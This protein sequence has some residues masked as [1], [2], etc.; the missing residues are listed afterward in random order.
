MPGF[1]PEEL[2]SWSGGAWRHGC[3]RAVGGIS[4]DT[5]QLRPGDLY[6]ALSGT[7]FDGHDFVAKAAAAGAC[8]AVVSR[9][10][11][12]GLGDRLPLLEVQDPLIALQEMAASYRRKRGVPIVGVT[13]STG[14]TTVKEMIAGMLAMAMPTARSRGNWNNE[15]GLPL[16]L[17]AMGEEARAGVFELGISH[18][19]EMAPLCRIA[20]PTWGVLTLIGP[21][22]LEFFGS[23]E[24]IAREKGAMLRCLPPEGA[25]VL[26]AD[27]PWFGL[28]AGMTRVRVITVSRKS[29]A[30]YRLAASDG[31]GSFAIEERASG[32]TQALRVPLPGEHIVHDALLAAAVARG[33]G[34]A[35]PHIAEA[36]A[37]Y[38]PLPMRWETRTAGGLTVIND[39][40]NSNP[41]S[42]AA[43]LRAFHATPAT[44]RKW[45]VLG[46]MLEI[47]D[48]AAAEHRRIGSVV[49]EGD[50]AGLVCVGDLGAAIA[51][52]AG[53]AGMPADRLRRCRTPAEAG[54]FLNVRVRPGDMVL[55]KAS[56]GIHLEEA[57]PPLLEGLPNGGAGDTIAI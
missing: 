49:A 7:N 16:S 29:G 39:A 30:D 47:G 46:D 42:L 41:L 53:D 48:G 40:Y 36:L 10:R 14:K 19:G 27:D 44:G 32:A 21:V 54:A 22:H 18:P 45:L 43:A 6:V 20:Q 13:G 35:W 9:A 5:R 8:G 50:W 23:E 52:G 31:A 55:L 12:G 57:L 11:A 38:R 2:A 15:V 51:D 37:R 26:C 1:S 17:L 34:V 4:Q 25:A 33:F 56:R 28:L 3:P 24:A